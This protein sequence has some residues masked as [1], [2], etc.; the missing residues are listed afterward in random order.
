MSVLQLTCP[1]CGALTK[2][3]R[4]WCAF[5]AANVLIDSAGGFAYPDQEGDMVID[6]TTY[7]DDEHSEYYC[8]A[9]G[10]R[11]AKDTK[12]LFEKI[13]EESRGV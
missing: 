10:G 2:V 12:E 5:V 4:S 3:R 7:D 13:K 8:A 11:I 1:E 6:E 9:C